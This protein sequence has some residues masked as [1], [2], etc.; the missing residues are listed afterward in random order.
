MRFLFY[1]SMRV[2]SAGTLDCCTMMIVLVW[3]PVLSVG[4]HATKSPQNLSRSCMRN[5]YGMH[6]CVVL[7]EIETP[8]PE[9]YELLYKQQTNLVRELL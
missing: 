8:G 1:R 2:T 3:R 6:N 7:G 4:K 5:W 9:N